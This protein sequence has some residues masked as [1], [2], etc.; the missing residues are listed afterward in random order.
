M[1]T[2]I[3]G[4][5]GAALGGSLI[6]GTILGLTG[7][8]IGGF[9]GASIGSVVDS[10]IISSLAPGQRIEGARLDS[11]RLTSSTEGAVIPRVSGRMRMGGNI[12]WA[13]DFREEVRTTTQ[14][15]GGKGGGGSKVTTTEY[16]YYASFAVALAELVAGGDRLP[17][18]WP[19][20]APPRGA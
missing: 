1:A 16:L 8:A 5:A 4:A 9:I 20:E 12:I 7:A 15:V 2:L 14:R 10:W 11:L 13:T 17:R 18:H 6:S 3:L 19:V